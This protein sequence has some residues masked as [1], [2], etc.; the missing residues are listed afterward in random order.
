MFNWFRNNQKELL[1]MV[2]DN[3]T[4][5]PWG[6]SDVKDTFSHDLDKLY[7]TD[8]IPD[9][10]K[11]PISFLRQWLNEDRNCKPLV[12]NQEIWYWLNA[13]KK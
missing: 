4:K 12:T 1:Q 11:Q 10:M 7:S 3:E 13:G 2:H 6:D 8:G 9:D 5:W